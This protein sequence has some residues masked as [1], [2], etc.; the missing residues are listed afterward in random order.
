MQK[1]QTQI[2]SNK[3]FS[4]RYQY[5][6][7]CLY[8]IFN[9]DKYTSI[10]YLHWYDRTYRHLN[11]VSCVCIFYISEDDIYP[12]WRHSCLRA[13]FSL[14]IAEDVG[15]W[16]PRDNTMFVK[17]VCISW[18]YTNNKK[19]IIFADASDVSCSS[20]SSIINCSSSRSSSSRSSRSSS[21]SSN[22]RLTAVAIV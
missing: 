7:V 16:I 2:H 20:S 14:W 4:Y 17:Y 19:G 3:S 9:N 22:S 18:N 11:A 8:V 12:Y 21:S 6:N 10:N 13:W 1:A 15:E 5:F